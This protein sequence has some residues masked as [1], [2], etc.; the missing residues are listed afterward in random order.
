MSKTYR[1][2]VWGPGGVGEHVLRYLASRADLDL[3][4]VRCYSE[5]KE[6]TDPAAALGLAPSGVT[7]TRNVEALLALEADCVIYTPRSALT[8]HTLPDSPD[9]ALEHELIAILE[10]GKNVVSP[11]GSFMHWRHLA[12]GRESLDRINDA[13]G[14][15]DSSAYFTGIDPGFTDCVLGATVASLSGEITQIRSW[16]M[17]DY[18]TYM[19]AE[20]ISAMGFGCTPERVPASTAP[21]MATWGGSPWTLADACDVELDEIVM[22]GDIWVSPE[23]YT[24]TNGLVVEAGTVGAIR[25]SLSGRRDG[26]TWVQL[27]HVN[28]LGAHAAPDWPSIGDAGGYRIE[29]DGFP[30]VRGDFPFG[31]PGGT[32]DGLKDAMAMT[33]GRLVNCIDAVVTAEPGHLTPNDLRM[34]G[35]RHGM[36]LA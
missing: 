12:N 19:V 2:I 23:T 8:D 20:T 5:N 34:I 36:A 30:P 16:E 4:G 18:S 10:S 22:D 1:V 9:R 33:A 31:L 29:V 25:F 35:P 7:A 32:G 15:G 26:K 3:V 21:I 11:I 6:G 14:R 28:R 27:N 24:A 13:C 17:I